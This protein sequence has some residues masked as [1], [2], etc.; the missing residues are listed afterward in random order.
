MNKLTKIGVSALCGSLAAVSAAN[1]GAISVAGGANATWTKL[2]YGTTG[3][4]LGMSTYMTFTGSG[5]LENGSSVTLNITHDDQNA[6]SSADIAIS[7]PGMGTF[8][9]DQG[10]GTG[11]DRLD[12]KMPTAWEETDGTA[13]GAGLQTVSGA[14]GG[15]DIEWAIDS[16]ML[17]DGMSAY[18]SYAPKA[19]GK[20]AN[21]KTG[22]GDAGGNVDGSGWDVVIEHSG[23][24][25][26]LNVFAG[27]SQIEQNSHMSDRKGYAVG[28]TY[29]VGPVTLGYQYTKDALNNP[30][31]TEMY[32][33]NA[34]GISFNVSDDLSIS[35]GNHESEKKTKEA[36]GVANG[37]VDAKSIQAAYSMGGATIKIAS[38]TVDNASYDS[39]TASDR[40]GTT[41]MLSLAF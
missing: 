31:G 38:T 17:P 25:D 23:L 1:A 9:V 37:T 12:D 36:T 24:G 22:G 27:Y 35:Y 20:N 14:G 10:G 3:T 40:S 28:A 19:D 4:P 15:N 13:V 11:L 39:T 26:G 33:N 5:D 34:Y 21:D 7:V 32:E 41:M 30:G 8:K 29:A 6:F 16:G 18:L 2:G